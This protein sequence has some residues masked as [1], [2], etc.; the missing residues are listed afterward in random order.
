MEKYRKLKNAINRDCKKSKEVFLNNI[1][2]D[3]N[4]TLKMGQMDKAYG[5]VRRFFKERKS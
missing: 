4:E 1:C 2:Q 5:M 3:I